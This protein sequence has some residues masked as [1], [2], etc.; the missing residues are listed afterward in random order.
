MSTMSS[1]SV[2]M[3]RQAKNAILAVSEDDAFLY[4]FCFETQ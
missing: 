2:A 3:L 1:R 4:L